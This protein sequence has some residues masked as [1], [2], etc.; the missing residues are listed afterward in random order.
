MQVRAHPP[1]PS[2]GSV[3]IQLLD[4]EFSLSLDSNRGVLS[5]MRKVIRRARADEKGFSLI[6]VVVTVAIVIALSVGGMVSYSGV[7]HSAK[8]AVVKSALDQVEIR[9]VLLLSGS[10]GGTP[11]DIVE[12]YNA[13]S[14]DL[15]AEIERLPDNSGTYRVAV[16]TDLDRDGKID[17]NPANIAES[18]PRL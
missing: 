1:P 13:T 15:A 18:F 17:S 16:G 4:F 10:V 6:D 11:E 9:L 5:K 14:K 8:Q 3:D 2:L 7:I 12:Q